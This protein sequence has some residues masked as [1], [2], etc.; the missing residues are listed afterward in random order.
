MTTYKN[1][2]VYRNTPLNK[3]FLDL[4]VPPI[5][6]NTENMKTRKISAKYHRRPDL[7]AYDLYGNS[8]YWWVFAI[9][10]RSKIKDP[11]FDFIEGLEI[12]VPDNL[13][14]IGL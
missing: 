10:N 4:Y 9:L 8:E 5:S 13:Q 1:T 2:S 11:L 7:M 14:T 12:F 6:S 3:K